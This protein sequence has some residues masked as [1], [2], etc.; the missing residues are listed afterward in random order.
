MALH[1]DSLLSA[2]YYLRERELFICFDECNLKCQLRLMLRCIYRHSL[3]VDVI[4]CLLLIVFARIVEKSFFIA[5]KWWEG[6]REREK[7]I[8]SWKSFLNL[9]EKHF[10]LVFSL[11]VD[12]IF[13]RGAFGWM[14]RIILGISF[15]KKF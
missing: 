4:N 15:I 5:F 8:I 1:I 7:K 9:I 13:W 3:D 10:Y 2:W 14:G 6:A 12:E 11:V